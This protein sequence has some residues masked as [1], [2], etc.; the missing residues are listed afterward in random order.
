MTHNI[1]SLPKSGENKEEKN[2][3]YVL[4]ATEPWTIKYGD[5]YSPIT[6]VGSSQG[7]SKS[8]LRHRIQMRRANGDLDLYPWV[9]DKHKHKRVDQCLYYICFDSEIN[10]SSIE[11][12][13]IE[14]FRQVTGYLRLWNSNGAKR[15]VIN[16][17]IYDFLELA[18]ILT[19][20]Q[21]MQPTEFAVE[22]SCIDLRKRLERGSSL[23]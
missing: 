17:E 12:E 5:F 10:T 15:L 9:E 20:R 8:G 4:S 13:I 18:G 16:N 3:L 1:D 2:T 14:S 6:Y 23:Q 22:R 19:I 21:A 11:K 7:T